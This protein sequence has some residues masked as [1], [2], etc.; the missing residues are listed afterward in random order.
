MI[1]I[2]KFADLIL[3]TVIEFIIIYKKITKFYI[4]NNF[5]VKI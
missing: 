3:K 5:D 1:T 2:G 4:F